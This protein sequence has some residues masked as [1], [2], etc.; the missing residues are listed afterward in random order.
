MP[1]GPYVAGVPVATPHAPDTSAKGPSEGNAV[2]AITLRLLLLGIVY[3]T[4]PEI[5]RGTLDHREDW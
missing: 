4:L 1:A 3:Y 5:V 2:T